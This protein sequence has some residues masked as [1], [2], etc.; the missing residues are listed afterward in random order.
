[1]R[2]HRHAFTLLEM[3]V[4]IAIV[5]TLLGL[6]LAAVERVREA[7]ARASCENNLHQIGM[8][9]HAFHDNHSF[10]PSSGGFPK[11]GNRPPTPNI[12]TNGKPWGVGDPRWPARQQPGPWAYAILP[13]LEQSA[14]YETQDYGIAVNCYQCPSRAREIAQ[15][16]PAIDPLWRGRRYD[17]GGIT[18]WGKTDYA[19]NLGIMLGNL[20]L[21]D[22]PTSTALTGSVSR[23]AD[24]RDGTSNTILAAEKSLDP[25]AYNTGGWFWD[26]PIFAGGGAGGAVRSG[27]GLFRDV[28][29]VEFGNNWGSAHP[30]GANFLFADV[31]VRLLTY[32]TDPNVLGALLTP[33]GGESVQLP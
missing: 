30:A 31:S 3:L 24:V 12:S 4:V 8:A 25:R 23:I 21:D 28:P 26:E 20:G 9:L 18:L 13:Y 11:G 27:N 29:G 14:A 10:F 2:A 17:G 7:A 5:G 16:V 1:M 32:D 22:N 33:S 15:N 19:G 6:L